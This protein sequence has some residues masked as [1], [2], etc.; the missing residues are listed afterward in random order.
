[1]GWRERETDGEKERE[2]ERRRQMGK[3]ALERDEELKRRLRKE[4]E[5]DYIKRK[6]ALVSTKTIL[7]RAKAYSSF[8]CEFLR[9]L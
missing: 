2:I 1:M 7:Y 4:R 3:P 9:I 8:V 5:I 6:I